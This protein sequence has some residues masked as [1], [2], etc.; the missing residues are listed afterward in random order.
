M[1]D[2]FGFIKGKDKGEDSSLTGQDEAAYLNSLDHSDLRFKIHKAMEDQ[3]EVA[4]NEFVDRARDLRG[5][6]PWKKELDKAEDLLYE[7]CQCPAEPLPKNEEE[8]HGF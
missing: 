3:D 2:E 6:Y 1:L 7:L 4:L 8:D 5:D